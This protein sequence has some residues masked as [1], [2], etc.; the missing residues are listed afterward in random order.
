MSLS[1]ILEIWTEIF[2]KR[3]LSRDVIFKENL[4]D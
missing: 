2:Y 3:Q 1:F 4:H